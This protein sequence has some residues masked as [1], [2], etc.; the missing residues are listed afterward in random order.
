MLSGA[1]SLHR[2][3]LMWLLLPQLVLWMAGAYFTYNLAARYAN[4]AIDATLSQAS[5]ALA[6]QVKPIDSGLFIDF[7]RAAQD[8]LESDPEDRVFYTVSS[9]PGQFILGNRHLPAPQMTQ[10][11]FGEPYF[12][13][14][15][16][17]S[18]LGSTT[19]GS[20]DA[21]RVAAL[22]LRYATAS[23]PDQTMLVQVARSSAN[24][25]ELA[26]SILVD[27]LLP[28][29]GVMLLMSM[30]VWAGIRAG[31]APLA[32]LQHKVEGRAANLLAPIQL[33]AAPPEVR[34][35][36]RAM[37]DLLEE[38][39][40]SVMAQKRFISDAAHQL[41]TPLAGLKSQTE[42]ALRDATDPALAARLQ[43]VHESATRSA[44]LVNQLL[45]LA[46]AEPESANLQDRQAVDLR[47]L[48]REL[49]AETVPRALQAGVDLGLDE[50]DEA[51]GDD[52][53]LQ[54]HGITLLLR[55]AL[56]NLL[57]NAIRYAGKGSTV[58]V[59]VRRQDEQAV[60]EVEDN[61]PGVPEQELAHVVQRF[62][63][64]T[65]DGTGCGLGLAIVREIVERHAGSFQ[66]HAVGPHGLLA[67]ASLPLL[68]KG[69]PGAAK[70]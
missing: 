14:A 9:P 22:Y 12:Y 44:H 55:E 64:A 50:A 3:L 46:R 4:R 53:A 20:T 11:D 48:A 59:R 23:T 34:S 28:L 31:L 36:A 8:I 39:N 29:S 62:V 63:R 51:D 16:V 5:R 70:Y 40:H 13:D 2:Q 57:D 17:P 41:R 27:T 69:K 6:R 26:R 52:E 68:G 45:T 10:P 25:E 19:A 24:R 61:G 33:E 65:Q 43:R 32:L 21:V 67:R 49:T 1:R 66:L 47:R 42:L 35:L 37:N 58:T 18:A 7:P 15:K 56:A 30:V 38:V 60:L 54:V